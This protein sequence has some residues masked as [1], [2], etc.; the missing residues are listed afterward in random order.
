MKTE[1]TSPWIPN[2]NA[3]RLVASLLLAISL[4]FEGRAGTFTDADWISLNTHPPIS[5]GYGT[6]GTMLA[7]GWGGIYV[8]ENTGSVGGY[9]FEFQASHWDGVTWSSLG[10]GIAGS[11]LAMAG[12]GT[13][14]YVAGVMLSAGGVPVS[15]IAKWDGTTWS[16]LGPGVNYTVRALAVSGTNLYAGGGFGEAGGV[17]ASFIARWDGTSWHA[18]GSGLNDWVYAILPHGN[19]LYVAGHFSTAGG[20]PANNIAK[21]DGTNWSSLGS[22][23][24]GAPF[25]KGGHALAMIG[26][27]LYVGGSFT[28]A[29]GIPANHI[30]KWNGSTWSA[31]GSGLNDYADKLTINGADLYVGGIF[32]TAGGV[33]AKNIAKWNGV[34]WSGIP[35]GYPLY[36]GGYSLVFSGTNFYVGSGFDV[37]R[38]TGAGWSPTSTG[39][40]NNIIAMA[41]NGTNLYVIEEVFP[42]PGEGPP[43]P[44]QNRILKR[45]A[46]NWSTISMELNEM[47]L[48]LAASENRLYVGGFFTSVDG[49]PASHIA[50]WD[51]ATWSPLGSGLD[52]PPGLFQ[53]S[54]TNL[55]VA[56]AF[57]TA[58]GVPANRIARWDGS[59][60]SALGSG[61]D[62][63]ILGMTASGTDLYVA[64]NFANA[65]GA[66]VEEIAKWDGSTWSSLGS[67][68]AGSGPWGAEVRALAVVGTNLYAGGSFHTAGGV[69]ANNIARW[70]GSAWHPMATGI[71]E[72]FTLTGGYVLALAAHGNDLYVGG[73]F[74]DAGGVPARCL[75]KWDGN[76]WSALGSGVDY[77]IYQLEA[78]NAGHLFIRGDFQFGGTTASPR[79]VQANIGLKIMGGRFQNWSYSPSTGFTAT[80]S[81]GTIGQPYRIQTAPAG[82]VSTWTDLTNFTYTGPTVITDASTGTASNKLYRAVTP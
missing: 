69:A 49:T 80:F 5:T 22:G 76:A 8:G 81:D 7:D 25:N 73:Y 18:L 12:E 64:G 46:E 60:W 70:D 72:P 21:W 55:Y 16:A 15:H 51:G 74:T 30:A 11:V 67:G 14:L 34:S 54:G 41:V 28:T 53:M 63:V 17:P 39:L 38:W 13:N 37:A 71:A 4:P 61:V 77:T 42:P 50:G 35:T 58:G 43:P 32:S 52:A 66:P 82:V 40:S 2:E 44:N 33:P 31:L 78:D 56:G 45:D 10:Q 20:I 6:V 9:P 79:I 62:D 26:N 65:G 29:G 47:A 68:F 23:L 75:A 1:P 19:D 3:Q 24:S 57:S 27:D 36:N 48:L 59:S